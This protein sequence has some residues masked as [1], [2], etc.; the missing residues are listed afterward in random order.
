MHAL[1]AVV[2]RLIVLN[3]GRK[4]AEGDPR[5]GDGFRRG[6]AD[7][8][9]H[10]GVTHAVLE[11]RGL[12]AFYGDFQALFG[13]DTGLTQGETIAII[14]ANGA[15]KST[16]LKA[17]AGLIRAAPDSVRVRGQADRRARRRRRSSSSASRWC[18]R[19][20]GCFPR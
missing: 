9:R 13:I 1:L 16:Y 2:G 14:G 6:A 5:A 8:Y 7:L 20:G 11:T 17:I 10:R 4:I 19:G 3:F 12:T 15:G 18:R